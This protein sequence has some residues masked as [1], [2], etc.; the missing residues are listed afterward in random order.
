VRYR[1]AVLV[2][3]QEVETALAHVAAARTQVAATHQ[4]VASAQQA[5]RYAEL[6]YERG[7]TP[8]SDRL[9]AQRAE[10]DAQNDVISAMQ[11]EAVATISLYKAI[12]GAMPARKGL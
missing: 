5:V 11:S 6:L 3:V 12:G 4:E 2:G 9:D 1:Q 7:L 8:L 10:L